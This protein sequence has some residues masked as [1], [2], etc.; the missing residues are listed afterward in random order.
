MIFS[1]SK[2]NDEKACDKLPSAHFSHLFGKL[3][4][5]KNLKMATQ[6]A[7]TAEISSGDAEYAG[8]DV[9]PKQGHVFW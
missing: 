1:A 2:Q 8:F 6:E 5:D 4:L 9:K 3:L 7:P